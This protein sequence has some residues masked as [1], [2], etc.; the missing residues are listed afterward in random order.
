MNIILQRLIDMDAKKRLH[1]GFL[2]IGGS[3]QT[4]ALMQQTIKDFA[5]HLFSAGNDD[6]TI[7]QKKIDGQNHPD[8]MRLSSG[9]SE[10]KIEQIRELQKWL[11]LPPLEAT[12]KIA[13]IEN[14]Q[15]L[16]ASCSN[17]LLKTLEEPPSYAMIILETNSVSRILP[18]IRSRLFGIQFPQADQKQEQE[19]HEWIGELESLL[20]R[21]NYTD[22]DIFTFTETLSDKRDDLGQ[23][24]NIVQKYIREQMF[25]ADSNR[26]NRLEKVFDLALQLEQELF[27]SYGNISLGLDR[28]F[29]EWRNT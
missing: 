2:F 26:F 29:M 27:Q 22:K 3:E 18:T 4:N 16:N 23:F 28:F 11:S 20:A 21:K 1:H 14:A 9:E 24:F 25:Q 19:E 17:A 5:I 6:K 15:H 10:I 7:I 12:K 8:Y 13:I